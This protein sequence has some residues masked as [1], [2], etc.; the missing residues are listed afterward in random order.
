MLK[1]ADNVLTVATPFGGCGGGALGAQRA[2]GRFRGLSGSVRLLGGYDFSAYACKAFEYLT[3]VEQTCADA[4]ALTADDIRRMWGPVAPYAVVS[5]PPCV[6][7][8]PLISHKKAATER[9]V[10][11]NGLMLPSTQTILEAYGPDLL[12]LPAVFLFENVP[13]LG[14]DKRGGKTL[15]AL[16]ALLTSYGY[17]IH[18]GHHN[19][20]HI[21]NGAQNRIRLLIVARNP[22]RM[23]VFLY[24]PPHR[25]GLVVGDVLGPLPLP[26]DPAGG[27]MHRT[28]A[29]MSFLNRLRL[30]AIPA[31]KDWRALREQG[32][33]VAL[34]PSKARFKGSLGV[35]AADQPSGAVTGEAAPSTG[36]YNVSAQVPVD[37]VPQAG[38][39][40]LHTNKYV[41]VPWDGT[42]GAVTTATRIGS[43]AP[44]VAQPIDLATADSAFHHGAGPGRWGV[45]APVDAASTVTS[46]ARINTGP[47]SV[48]AAVPV[49]L[50][51]EK[52][53]FPAGY[54]VLAK[55]QP[56]R[57]I[58]STASVG[59]GAYAIADDVPQPLNL[60][61][62]CA[63]RAGSYGVQA[64]EDPSKV[65]I[66]H[67]KVDNST[68][69]VA[70]PRP[71]PRYVILSCEQVEQIVR[72]E[73]RV[74]FAIVD[75]ENPGEA[76]AIVD[77]LKK[78]AYRVVR[79]ERGRGQHRRIVERREP[80][81]V[82]LVSRDGMW[83]R[84]MT[85]L[86]LAVLQ[87]FP[88]MH[89]GVALDFG[90]GPTAQRKVIGNAIPP[91]VM[92]AIFGQI[93]ISDLASKQSFF[94]SPSDWEVWVDGLRREGYEVISAG[95][96][97]IHLGGGVVLDDGAVMKTKAR[98]AKRAK[99]PNKNRRTYHA[100][101]HA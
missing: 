5:S 35:L 7:A 84:E 26:D 38:N 82:V 29:K 51:P 42:A 36:A 75:P 8:T 28:T 88:W 45:L 27:P 95:H 30:W 80:V 19:A 43:G 74:P 86:E 93:I 40:N 87:Q 92:E 32:D 20:R 22:A 67:A 33:A 71:A 53:C 39:E 3:G 85:T 50:V 58:K 47:F 15:K 52:A 73:V 96:G 41:V 61:L 23:P 21:G 90:G 11:M 101:A 64:F 12:D 14:N 68:A 34:K 54:G 24:K 76:L 13:G 4:T 2:V 55:D 97:P 70:D 79:E 63:P 72:G 48:A 98:K 91:T 62:N 77:D 59:C 65:V 49:D 94:L 99:P 100:H 10:E 25:K 46:N 69:A 16:C 89:N 6:G 57:T 18:K 81:P 37:L 83:H 9:Y 44:G 78:P 31:G 56:S 66:A 60:A 1:T 17:V